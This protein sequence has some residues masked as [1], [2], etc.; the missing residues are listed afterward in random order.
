[1]TMCIS[2][3]SAERRQLY[4]KHEKSFSGILCAPVNYSYK[5]AIISQTEN[6]I[7][8]RFDVH[9]QNLVMQI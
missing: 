7:Q 5:K 2:S 4:L 8:R 9:S 3:A 1:M 6:M